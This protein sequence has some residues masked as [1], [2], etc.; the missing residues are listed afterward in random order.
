MIYVTVIGIGVG[1]FVVPLAIYRIFFKKA[2]ESY[3]ER[4]GSGMNLDKF[5]AA[6]SATGA[7]PIEDSRFKDDFLGADPD[8]VRLQYVLEREGKK[9]IAMYLI[10]I[11]Q[12]D[13]IIHSFTFQQ[14][15]YSQADVADR[16]YNV[17]L[18]SRLLTGDTMPKMGFRKEGVFNRFGKRIG[19]N[20]ELQIGNIAFDDKV[21]IY[22]EDRDDDI[23]RIFSEP[24]LRLGISE[25][26]HG[27]F[28]LVGINY[29]AKG[30]SLTIEQV[31]LDIANPEL[32]GKGIALITQ[33]AESLPPVK[34]RTILQEKS[35]L[36]SSFQVVSGCAIFILFLASFF[37]SVDA[38]FSVAK[39]NKFLDYG[40]WGLGILAV[41]SIFNWRYS[42]GHSEGLKHFT[43]GFIF[44]V[45][46]SWMLLAQLLL[47]VN[48]GPSDALQVVELDIL[49]KNS[50]KD[51]DDTSFYVTLQGFGSLPS[52]IEVEVD[53][54]PFMNT[55]PGIDKYE[56]IYGEGR[57]GILWLEDYHLID[58]GKK[59][60]K[61]KRKK[62]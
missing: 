28:S 14:A 48:N 15:L 55:D 33:I 56:F 21:Y 5:A 50:Y 32:L 43:T 46:I 3:H 39:V 31:S 10:R 37:G 34:E 6:L 18:P 19:L 8:K 40:R 41:L 54:E 13:T 22:S 25:A 24:K 29:K 47:L 53:Y 36:A 52:E 60:R 38:Y 44:S 1:I 51:E 49:Q 27:E 16:K 20:K 26:V 62:K 12:G 4:H 2:V 17:H 59:K 61:N 58:L 23:K 45:L 30:V 9:P 42:A 57:L 35:S 7:R 11:S